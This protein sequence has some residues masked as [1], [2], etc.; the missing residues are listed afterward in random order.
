VIFWSCQRCGLKMWPEELLE[1]VRLL[2]PDFDKDIERW[3][4]GELAV[5]DETI[6]EE[7]RT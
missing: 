2:H 4:D 5:Y 7:F 3:A 1:H 6:D